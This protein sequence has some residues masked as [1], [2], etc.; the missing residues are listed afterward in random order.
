MNQDP[1]EFSD[2]EI[3]DHQVDLITEITYLAREI[4]NN[5]RRI[6]QLSDRLE[7]VDE[8][9]ELRDAKANGPLN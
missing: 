6:A 8:D 4:A 7:L 5:Q 9:M 2:S 1:S 3:L